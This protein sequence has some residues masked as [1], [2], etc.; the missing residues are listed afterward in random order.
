MIE[1]DPAQ[2]RGSLCGATRLLGI[3]R[4]SLYGLIETQDITAGQ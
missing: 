1:P 2:S 4:P 3:S